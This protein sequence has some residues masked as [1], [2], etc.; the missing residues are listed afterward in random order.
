[1]RGISRKEA[2]EEINELEILEGQIYSLSYT[3]LQLLQFVTFLPKKKEGSY[4][5]LHDVRAHACV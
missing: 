2:D 4:N 5:K 3:T 1:M